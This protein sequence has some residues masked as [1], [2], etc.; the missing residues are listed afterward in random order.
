MR[1]GAS[2]VR[3]EALRTGARSTVQP[4]PKMQKADNRARKWRALVISSQ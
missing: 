3:V 2:D 4:V 1:R